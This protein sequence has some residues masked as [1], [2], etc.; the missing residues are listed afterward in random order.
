MSTIL[1][2]TLDPPQAVTANVVLAIPI[3]RML[4]P[5]L[6]AKPASRSPGHSTA[7]PV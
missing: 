4:R 7:V 3:D 2:T 1:A 5:S 6:N